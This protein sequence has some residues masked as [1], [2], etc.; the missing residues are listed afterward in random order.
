[1]DAEGQREHQLGEYDP[2]E[3]VHQPEA[4]GVLKG[5]HRGI[6]QGYHQGEANGRGRQYQHRVEEDARCSSAAKAEAGEGIGGGNAQRRGEGGGGRRG[7]HT[8][9]DGSPEP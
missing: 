9:P 7:E 4:Q 3:A 2:R 8:E 6:L 1:V 5:E